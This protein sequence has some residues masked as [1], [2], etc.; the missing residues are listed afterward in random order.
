MENCLSICWWGKNTIS[1]KTERYVDQV[2]S[3]TVSPML[4]QKYLTSFLRKRWYDSKTIKPDNQSLVLLENEWSIVVV[5]TS[6]FNILFVVSTL[7]WHKK[8]FFLLDSHFVFWYLSTWGFTSII[9]SHEQRLLGYVVS[10]HF[11]HSSISD[12]LFTLTTQISLTIDQKIL[13]HC[14]LL[15]RNSI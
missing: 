2:E 12:L 9:L 8:V 5:I 4:P 15:Q 14:C 10:S 3:I 11:I 7:P 1:N 13:I 6:M